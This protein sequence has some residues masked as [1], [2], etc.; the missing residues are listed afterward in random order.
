VPRTFTLTL[1]CPQRPGIVH[2]VSAFLFQHGCD[3]VEHQQFDD[4]IR[5]S[6][7]LRAALVTARDADADDLSAA[8]SFLR[9]TGPRRRPDHRAGGDPD[10]PH[11]R[12]AQP[13][14]RSAWTRMRS[15]CRARAVRWHC[16]RRVLLN[17]RS[18][19]VFR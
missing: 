8:H 7:F 4:P 6:L 10:R 14:D 5:G 9:D 19:V 13:L 17:D 12:P 11:L 15:R 16:E 18:T 3:I 1:S 2:A